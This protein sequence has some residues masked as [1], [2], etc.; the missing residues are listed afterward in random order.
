MGYMS[1]SGY[2]GKDGQRSLTEA[3]RCKLFGRRSIEKT[4]CGHDPKA[5]KREKIKVGGSLVFTV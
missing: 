3:M 1:S 4:L 5:D 2:L